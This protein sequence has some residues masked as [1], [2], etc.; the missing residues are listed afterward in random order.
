MDRLVPSNNSPTLISPKGTVAVQYPSLDYK[1]GTA[2]TGAGRA[3]PLVSH[4]PGNRLRRH[5]AR[6]CRWSAPTSS[7]ATWSV[8]GWST[9]RP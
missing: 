2:L 4:G 6:V 9:R 8:A 1:D 5:G 7:T 3:C